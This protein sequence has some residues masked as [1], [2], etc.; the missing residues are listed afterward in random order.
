MTLVCGDY[1][2]RIPAWQARNR[3]ARVKKGPADLPRERNRQRLDDATIGA[4]SP[5]Q[6]RSQQQA[7][8]NSRRGSKRAPG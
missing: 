3:P 7:W 8:S 6:S 2:L 1:V 5:G 4:R